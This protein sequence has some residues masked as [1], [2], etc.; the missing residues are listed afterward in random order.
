M[1]PSVA[2]VARSVCLSV[3][4][5]VCVSV[6]LLGMSVSCAKTDEPIE[7]PFGMWTRGDQDTKIP[8]IRPPRECA[9]WG[10]VSRLAVDILNLFARGQRSSDTASGY[11]STVLVVGIDPPCPLPAMDHPP[12]NGALVCGTLSHYYPR[13]CR[14]HCRRGYELRRHDAQHKFVCQWDG[15]WTIDGPWPDCYCTCYIHIQL[16]AHVAPTGRCF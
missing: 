8:R 14:V 1:Q 6:F 12:A 11:Q 4:L 5:S 2:F 9:L 15:T 7:M 10:V 16:L 13:V 3:C